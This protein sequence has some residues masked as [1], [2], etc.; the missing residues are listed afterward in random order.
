MESLKEVHSTPTGEEMDG[1]GNIEFLCEI[2]LGGSDKEEEE[3]F[4]TKYQIE[5]IYK[6]HGMEETFEIL[7]KW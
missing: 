3:Q 1:D 5:Q 6:E 4:M 7:E 2:F